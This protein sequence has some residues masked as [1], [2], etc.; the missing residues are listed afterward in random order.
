LNSGDDEQQRENQN[1]NHP[2]FSK[3]ARGDRNGVWRDFLHTS[4][5]KKRRAFDVP[6]LSED[7]WSDRFTGL[8]DEVQLHLLETKAIHLSDVTHRKADERIVSFAARGNLETSARIAAISRDLFV[9][10]DE[11]LFVF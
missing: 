3:A 8:F 10:A 4:F 7:E 2:C 9:V 11:A 1:A 6:V 5:A